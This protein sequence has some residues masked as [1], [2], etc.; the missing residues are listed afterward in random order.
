M[1]DW[2]LSQALQCAHTRSEGAFEFDREYLA[3]KLGLLYVFS[4]VYPVVDLSYRYYFSLAPC[5]FDLSS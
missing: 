4:F 3:R 5:N 1:Q 2:G